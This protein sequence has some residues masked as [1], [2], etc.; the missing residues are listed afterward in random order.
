MSLEDKH[1]YWQ[2]VISEWELSKLSQPVFCKEHD[3]NYTQF[4]TWRYKF[5]K[6]KKSQSGQFIP[7]KVSKEV[8]KS[9]IKALSVCLPEG[10]TLTIDDESQI[11][12]VANLLKAL[13]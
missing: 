3:I 7:V 9:T 6:A 1:A 12:M 13:R 2:R 11:I 10:V 8:E 4:C 5:N